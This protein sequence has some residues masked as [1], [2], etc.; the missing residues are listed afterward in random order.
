VYNFLTEV[1]PPADPFTA[2]ETAYFTANGGV[3]NPAIGGANVDLY[4]TGMSNT[5]K[6]LAGFS[7][8]NSAAYLHII[9][10]AK[11]L[12]GGQTNITVTYLGASGDS[13]YMPGFA[14]RT[15]IL[16][17]STG[18]GN[19]SYTNNFLPT[20]QTNVLSGGSGLGMVTNMTDTA[21]PASS[22][23]YYRVRVLLP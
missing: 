1:P 8:T 11:A 18:T 4:G 15:N 17:Y 6:F 9:G 21:I 5:N 10:I 22:T 19:G 23:R 16:E 7:G 14:S 12:T 20:G 13:T 3:T 2:W